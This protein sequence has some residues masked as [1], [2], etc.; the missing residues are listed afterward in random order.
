VSRL[1]SP[2]ALPAV[3]SGF[4]AFLED[5]EATA[6]EGMRFVER[7][8]RIDERIPAERVESYR[9]V[10]EGP[11]TSEDEWHDRHVDYLGEAL[12]L[13]QP[14]MGLPKAVFPEDRATCAEPFRTSGTADLSATDSSVELIR[15]ER[16][17]SIAAGAGL[18][19]TDVERSLVIATEQD[20]SSSDVTLA[21]AILGRWMR[22]RDLRP[23]W[24]AFLEDCRDAIRD[25]DNDSSWP[26]VLR[27]RLGLL[28]IDPAEAG[29]P[30][31]VAVFRYPVSRV[32]T[33]RRMRRE[34]CLAYPTVMDGHLAP[35]FCPTPRESRWGRVVDLSA[36][37]L[38]PA[39]EILHPPL[40]LR[41][42]DI[43]GVGVVD[44]P[45]VKSVADARAW[46]LLWLQDSC[47]RHY[48]DETDADLLV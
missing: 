42:K 4:R 3:Y 38:D 26:S 20:A 33:L 31:P 2:G 36:P 21:G 16:I 40:V 44:Q 43:L 7:N 13:E 25:R 29:R 6:G 41:A 37:A 9:S 11:P 28:H 48:A 14:A 32:P 24:A 10:A 45:S 30:I 39:R 46:H 27:D 23:V 8:F 35:A 15:M 5:L 18:S 19:E 22:T 34:R 1:G 17:A 12:W 47:G